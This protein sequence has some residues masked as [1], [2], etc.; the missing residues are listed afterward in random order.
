LGPDP[1]NTGENM[2]G[3]ETQG[4]VAA[5]LL[6]DDEQTVLVMRL[7]PHGKRVSTVIRASPLIR[8]TDPFKS[9]IKGTDPF[10][11]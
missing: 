9:L 8:G 3:Q 11:S 10:R 5:T 4:L 2:N 6:D 7:G 1:W